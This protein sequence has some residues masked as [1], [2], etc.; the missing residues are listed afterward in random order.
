M[1]ATDYANIKSA[2]LIINDSV[3]G[4]E[5]KRTN[6]DIKNSVYIE[7]GRKNGASYVFARIPKTTN[8]GETVTPR[9]T[10]T[11]ADGSLTGTKI[12]PL[13]FARRENTA[14]VINAGLFDMTAMQPVGQTIIDGVAVVSAPMEDD[15]GV[16]ISA[17]ECY[18][19]CIDEN[20]DLSAPY[21]R[22]VA[23]NT[24]ISDG[25]KQAVVG[26]GKLVEN[27][28]IC[29]A[30]IAAEIVHPSDYIRQSIGQFENGDYFVCTVEQSRGTVT[31][32]AGMTY[33]ELAE[34]LI[35]KGAKFAYSLDGGGS[36]AT[37]IGKRQLN[38]IYEGT[39]GRAVPTVIYFDIQ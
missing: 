9:L 18:P 15:N 35:E 22:S 34:L 27:F 20:G 21:A 5:Q 23:V 38:R 6:D 3:I 12:S 33:T 19:L 11:S 31:N 32:E 28:K 10:L 2:L 26:W 25:V 24:M 7:Y 1:S 39:S 37:V 4:L 29:T 30:D 14:F 17:T 16:A 36:A 8:N 13:A